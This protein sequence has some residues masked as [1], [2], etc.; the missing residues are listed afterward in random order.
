MGYLAA[1][2]FGYLSVNTRNGL[3]YGSNLSPDG[4]TNPADNNGIV[5]LKSYSFEF[6]AG[7][8]IDDSPNIAGNRPRISSGSTAA[9]KFTLNCQYSRKLGDRSLSEIIS[10]VDVLYYLLTWARN[11]TIVMLFYMPNSTAVSWLNHGQE[12]DFYTSQLRAMYDVIWGGGYGV[13]TY[14]NVRFT[15]GYTM[16]DTSSFDACAIPVVFDNIKV[17]ELA[18]TYLVRIEITGYILENEGRE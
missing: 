3:Y 9:T 5:N 12:I 17:S 10:D 13:T 2:D 18:G 11:R 16:A 6:D 14:G 1:K 15:T 8:T 7:N 4:I